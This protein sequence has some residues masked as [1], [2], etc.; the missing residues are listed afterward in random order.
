MLKEEQHRDT[1]RTDTFSC[2]NDTGRFSRVKGSDTMIKHWQHTEIVSK[3]VYDDFVNH[4]IP[5]K[6]S[7]ILPYNTAVYVVSELGSKRLEGIYDFHAGGIRQLKNKTAPNKDLRLYLDAV[8][9]ENI[10]ILG[11]DG[12]MGTGKTSTCIENLIKMHLSNVKVDERVLNNP[13]WKPPFDAHKILIAKPAVNAG[14]EE[15]GFLPGDLKEKIAPMLKNY[16]QYFDRHHQSG[17]EMLNAAGYVEIL[18][19]GFIRGMDQENMTIIVDE[20]QNTKEL[21]T[22]ATRLAN[23]AR[24][25]LLGDTSPF[26]ID[27]AGNTPKKN[28]LTDIV[29][30]LRGAHYFQYIEMKSLEHIVRSDEVRD[31]VKRLFKKYGEDPQEWLE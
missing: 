30:L 19:L 20:A 23:K 26:Q 7:E 22:V 29:D 6:P 18:P 16:T 21:I 4:N 9:N 14:G 3:Q 24:I 15:Y 8:S 31:I 13:D 5:I 11:V 12:L 1:E 27:L 28:G 2:V 25:F 10:T 17:F